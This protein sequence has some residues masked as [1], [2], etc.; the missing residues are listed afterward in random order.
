MNLLQNALDAVAAQE[1]PRLAVAG[2]RCEGQ[3]WVSI[4][5][6]GPGVDEAVIEKVFDPFFTTRVDGTG[7]GLA[8][9][10][11]TAQAHGGS[12]EV[13]NLPAGGAQFTFR[14]RHDTQLND[15]GLLSAAAS[16]SVVQEGIEV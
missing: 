15:I 6:N 2:G 12:V 16:G 10:N 9:A 8:I 5:D 1:D 4:T 13:I 3:C 11:M 7:L 14:L